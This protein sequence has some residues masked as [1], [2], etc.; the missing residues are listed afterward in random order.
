MNVGVATRARLAG[1]FVAEAEETLT[2][3]AGRSARLRERSDADDLAEF[4]RAAHG[5]KGA[6]A[7]LGYD[8]LATAL[9][10]VEAL[11][12]ALSQEGPERAERHA[13]L[14]RALELLGQGVAQMGASGRDA[15]PAPVA[16]ALRAVLGG[17]GEAAVPSASVSPAAEAAPEGAPEAA[18]RLSVPAED[19]DEALRLAASLARALGRLQGALR[20]GEEVQDVQALCAGAERLESS[21]AGLRLLPAEIAFSGLEE[22]VRQL[23]RRLG[24]EVELSI[25]GREVRAD[26]RTLQSARTMIRHLVRNAVDHGLEPPDERERRGKARCGRISIGVEAAESALKVSVEDDGAGFDVPAI[27]E[28]LGRRSGESK[29]IAELSDADV[30]QLFAEEGGSTRA[31]ASEISGRGLGLSAVAGLA[32]AAGGGLRVS[33]RSG[34]GSSVS[35][36]LPL[37]V[38]A[39]EVLAAT[40]GGQT[41]GLPLSAVERTIFL[42]AAEDAI[43]EGPAGVTLAVGESIVPLHGLSDVLALARATPDRFAVVLRTEGGT[44]AFG[45]EDLGSVASV[46]PTGVP[47]IADAGALTTGLAQ[48]GGGEVVRILDPRRL[49]ALAR[50]TRPRANPTAASG[51][52]ARPK[53][54]LE[55]VLAEDSL[56]TREVLRVLLEEQG[57]RVRVAADGEE[58]LTRIAEKL[59]DVLVTDVNMPGRDGLSLT[60]QLRGEARTARLPVIL[61]TSIDDPG[62]QA[63]GAAAGAD[64]YLLK[65]RFNAGVLRETLARIGV[66]KAR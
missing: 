38:Y 31:S 4:G 14:E 43:H 26:R 2:L 11:S 58:A 16:K 41:L 1:L 20:G 18:E 46:V 22:E 35:F 40:A 47:G 45:V 5:L 12:L 29:R 49:V 36:S 17:R 6:A 25:R 27:R 57:F 9:H 48:L 21:I 60:R 62:T 63:A 28:E 30:L 53:A 23:G 44:A 34:L 55:V 54:L 51:Q 65:S 33:T 59:P 37:E 10:D 66:G 7:A 32:A 13:R 52:T 42:R 64:A 61:L 24:K 3:L 56:A 39:L 15:F 19:V 50:R 8:E